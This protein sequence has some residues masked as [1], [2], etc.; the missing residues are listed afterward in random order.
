MRI[1]LI[2]DIHG[3]LAAFNAVLEVITQ[4]QPDQIVC[5]GDSAA[6]GPQP[7]DV[8]V[9]LRELGCPVVMGNADVEMLSPPLDRP[10]ADEQTRK[11]DD[12]I[13]WG[14]AQ[15]DDADRAFVA[16]FQPT[17]EIS[18]GEAGTLLCCHGSPRSYDDLILSTT[19]NEELAPM[20]EGTAAAVQAGGHTHI[21][22]LRAW[23]KREIVN[24]GS[25]GLAFEH[26]LAGNPRVPP[27]AEF[28]MLSIAAGAVSIDFRRLPYDQSATIRAMHERGMPH[29][30]WWTE[31]WG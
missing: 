9:R 7:H 27:W 12:I 24:P 20:L 13:R 25:V 2:S 14:A 1:A 22:M 16:S 23:D 11:M 28:A 17:I 19:P 29:A 31:S 26:F 30:A 3:N 4:E 5:L 15:L 18:L 8:L 10:D 6:S 21:R